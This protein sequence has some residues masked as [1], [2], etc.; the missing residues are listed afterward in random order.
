M[1]WLICVVSSYGA[2]LSKHES[3][4]PSSCKTLPTPNSIVVN[5]VPVTTWGNQ[6]HSLLSVIIGEPP[7]AGVTYFET[8]V[9]LEMCFYLWQKNK[10]FYFII[11]LPSSLTL[12]L[13]STYLYFFLFFFFF[14]FILCSHFTFLVLGLF[15][16][17]S[18][19]CFF[20]CSGF[21]LFL[22]LCNLLRFK[23]VC[24]L[25]QS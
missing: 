3:L 22:F 23:M 25:K 1:F 21:F 20:V 15:D 14:Q 13:L 18:L 6:V 11:N 19:H 24:F 4:Q 7:V 5:F 8:Y 17:A 12:L 9:S 10:T 16:Y 2:E